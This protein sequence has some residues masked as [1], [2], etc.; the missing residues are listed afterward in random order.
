LT[1]AVLLLVF[2]PGKSTPGSFCVFQAA[3]GLPCGLCGGTRA[4]RATLQGDFPKALYLNPAALIIAA[5]A[6]GI[7]LVLLAEALLARVI[8]PPLKGRLRIALLALVLAT[9]VPWTAW[10][11]YSALITPKPELIIPGHP[12]IRY[13]KGD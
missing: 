1:L 8:L 6:G 11:A 13:L 7:S 9:L 4:L 2:W 12:L 5:A 3:T 10:H